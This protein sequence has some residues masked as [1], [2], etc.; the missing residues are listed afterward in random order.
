LE[1]IY[2][3]PLTESGLLMLGCTTSIR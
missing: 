2:V 1:E 3:T